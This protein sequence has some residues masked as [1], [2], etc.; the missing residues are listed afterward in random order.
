MIQNLWATPVLKTKIPEDISSGVAEWLLT[1]YN[2]QKPPSDFGVK[3]ILDDSDIMVRFKEEVVIPTFDQFLKETLGVGIDDWKGGYRTHAWITGT[4]KDYSINYHN[5]GGAQV[6]AVFYIMC[7]KYNSGGEICFTDPRQN[8]NRGYDAKF[9]KWFEHLKFTPESGDCV[10]FPS[11]LYHFVS[12]YQG[13]IRLAIPV[14]LFL[15]ANT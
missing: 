9:S 15:Y 2:L 11:F 12:T 4:G 5:H 7:E 1:E 8:S 6:S 3:N 10:V 14:D 13:N